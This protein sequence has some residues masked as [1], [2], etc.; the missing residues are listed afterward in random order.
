MQ[1]INIINIYLCSVSKHTWCEPHHIIGWIVLV[2]VLSVVTA[3]CHLSVAGC[4]SLSCIAK[5]YRINCNVFI[6]F[7]IQV[8]FYFMRCIGLLCVENVG[9]VHDCTGAQFRGNI[10]NDYI[11]LP[12]ILHVIDMK[13]TYLPSQDNHIATS[14]N[15]SLLPLVHKTKGDVGKVSLSITRF[16]FR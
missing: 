15:C 16:Y 13:I 2:I 12:N 5:W 8:G 11:E 6:L 14:L 7:T 4:H 10:A 1:P 9:A 3:C